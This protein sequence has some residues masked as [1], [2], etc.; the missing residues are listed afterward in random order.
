MPR[1]FRASGRGHGAWTRA[2]VRAWPSVRDEGWGRGCARGRGVC[3]PVRWLSRRRN[4]GDNRRPRSY[5]RENVGDGARPRSFRRE[6]TGDDAR[7]RLFRRENTGDNRRPRPFR[8]ENRADN[9]C[10]RIFRREN[11]EDSACPRPIR[12]GPSPRPPPARRSHARARPLPRTR[13]TS[14]APALQ[15]TNA[16]LRGGKGRRGACL[17]GAQTL[18][19]KWITSPSSTT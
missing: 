8:R 14:P 6:S 4:S 5:R 16:P 7:T 12:Q 3:G 17:S 15:N 18:N 19:R 13:R 2:G 1:R 9:A 10:P 11:P